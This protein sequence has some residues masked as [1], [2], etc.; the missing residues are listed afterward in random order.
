MGL[1]ERAEPRKRDKLARGEC[2]SGLF[3]YYSMM[4]AD[5]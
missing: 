3:S 5:I 1:L 4:A 2:E